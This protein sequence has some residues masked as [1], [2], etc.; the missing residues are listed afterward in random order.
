VKR[1]GDFESGAVAVEESASTGAS[2]KRCDPVSDVLGDK[3]SQPELLEIRGLTHSYSRQRGALGRSEQTA[4]LRDIDLTIP[5]STTLALVGASGSGKSTLA[6]CLTLMEK[7]EKGEIRF[8]G[9]KIAELKGKQLISYKRQVQMIYQDSSTS[10]N[11]RFTAMEIVAEPLVIQG[12]MR[13]EEI[14]GRAIAQMQ[15]VKLP[16]EFAQRRPLELSGGQRQRLAIARALM[17]E[18]KLLILD[19]ALSGFDLLVQNKILELLRELQKEELIAYLF[20]THDLKL[21][22][23]FADEVAVMNEGRIVER[24]RAREVFRSPG[25]E[26]TRRLA[27]AAKFSEAETAIVND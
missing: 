21:A 27:N 2:K 6:K 23:A 11:P 9:K 1:A 14:R 25:H 4:S 22:E 26:Y 12:G 16:E 15:R 13:N 8:N 5:A 18:P 17:L 24:G 10:F 20:I 7:P 19:E 3:R